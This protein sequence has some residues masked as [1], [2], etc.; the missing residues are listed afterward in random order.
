M[1]DTPQIKCPTCKTMM[2]YTVADCPNCNRRMPDLGLQLAKRNKI[3]LYIVCGILALVVGFCVFF[4]VK[5]VYCPIHNVA[6]TDTG[7]FDEIPP[8]SGHTYKV[9]R[10]PEGHEIQIDQCPT[11]THEGDR[12]FQEKEL[13]ELGR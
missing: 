6:M 2:P 12:R 1:A 13:K 5:P 9:Y 3:A 4:V 8:L 10:C 7:K 11:C